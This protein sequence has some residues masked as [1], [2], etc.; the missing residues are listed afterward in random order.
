[1][2]RLLY[3]T[4]AALAGLKASPFVHAVAALTVAVALFAA[5]LARF[6]L[7]AGSRALDAWGRDVELTLYLKDDVSADA[8]R[9]LAEHL[10][11]E[12]GGFAEVVT[13]EQAL[14]RLRSELGNAGDVLSNLPKNPL[15]S[16]IEA[17]PPAGRRSAAQ[18]AELAARASALPGVASVEY[19]RE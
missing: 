8:A 19:G 1:M 12:E 4:R 18:V 9:A 10:R 7:E 5:S 2:V 17:R 14:E 13:A 6:A 3:F 15:P 11:T 16:S